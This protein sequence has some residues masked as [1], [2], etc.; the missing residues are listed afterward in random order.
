M[1]VDFMVNSEVFECYLGYNIK[2]MAGCLV[3][4]DEILM[5]VEHACWKF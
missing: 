4:W 5:H 2:I 1:D 3:K